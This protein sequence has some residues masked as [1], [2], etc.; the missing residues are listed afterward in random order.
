MH[1]CV[2]TETLIVMEECASLFGGGC[3]ICVHCW[4]GFGGRSD[5]LEE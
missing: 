3:V 4:S 2:M 5:M 1:I